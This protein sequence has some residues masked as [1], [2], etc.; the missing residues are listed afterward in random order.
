MVEASALVFA[1]TQNMIWS[2]CNDTLEGPPPDAAKIQDEMPQP[3]MLPE[4][5]EGMMED[6]GAPPGGPPQAIL[7]STRRDAVGLEGAFCW[8]PEWADNCVGDAG[9]PLPEERET[10]AVKRGETLDLVFVLRSS[11]GRFDERD[12]K[13]TGAVAYPLNQETKTVPM[14]PEDRYLV[15]GGSS[16]ELTKEQLVI[17]GG[18]SLSKIKSAAPQGEYVLQVAVRSP[19]PPGEVESWRKVTYHFREGLTGRRRVSQSHFR[20][21]DHY[22]APLSLRAPFR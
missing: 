11:E 4:M 18:P 10:L 17:K 21:G 12:P 13:V 7:T 16:R 3:E 5:M 20:N 14:P 1:G 15:P 8:A 2:P 6:M 22:M 9:I 19:E